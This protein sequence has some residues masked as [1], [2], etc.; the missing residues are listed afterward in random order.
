MV[1]SPMTSNRTADISFIFSH[2]MAFSI[3]PVNT[4]SDLESSCRRLRETEARELPIFYI[5]FA[6]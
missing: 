3:D 2:L 5:F 6:H 4:L 1:F